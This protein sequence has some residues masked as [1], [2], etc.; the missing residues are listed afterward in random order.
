MTI[1]DS[2]PVVGESTI[3]GVEKVIGTTFPEAYRRFA[4]RY[5]GGRPEPCE[6]DI[7]WEDQDWADGWSSD[8]VDWFVSYH[9]GGVTDFLDYYK[10]FKGRIPADMVPIAHDPGGNLILLAVDGPDRGKVFF[11]FRAEE[12]EEGDEPDRRNVGFVASDF[13]Q[14]LRGLH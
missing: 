12:V 10:T 14:F 2:H 9:P 11:W 3:R 4:L 8:T 5:N 7:A 1:L 6:F 13:D